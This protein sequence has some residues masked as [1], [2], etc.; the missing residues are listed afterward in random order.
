MLAPNGGQQTWSF[1]Q[2]GRITGTTWP[3]GTVSLF[4]QTVTLDAA[5]QRTASNDSWGSTSYGYD[6][7]GRLTSASYP[8]G[9]SEAD[10]YDASGNRTVI[11]GTSTLAGS[12][13]I[14]NTYDLADELTGVA[15]TQG[16]TSYS[17]DGA[18]NQIGSHGITGVVTNTYNDLQ[19]L[20]GVVGPGTNAR[21][22]YDGQGDRLRGYEQSGISWALSTDVQ[23]LAGGLSDLVSDGAADYTYLAPGAGGAPAGRRWRTTPR[24]APGPAIWPPT[25]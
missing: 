15:S 20:T 1:D 21:Y 11:T 18:G 19:Q 17:Y 16:N 3:T 13:V 10:Q 9:S 24:A 6:L 25:C 22:V 4:T 7:A 14:T 5:G 8:D 12:N 23:D 2:A